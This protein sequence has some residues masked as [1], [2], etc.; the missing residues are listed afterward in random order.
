MEVLQPNHVG[1]IKADKMG[2]KERKCLSG[3]IEYQMQKD[4]ASAPDKPILWQVIE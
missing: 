1:S 4:L 2:G 3:T